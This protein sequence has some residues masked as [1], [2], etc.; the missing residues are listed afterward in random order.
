MNGAIELPGEASPLSVQTLAATLHAAT[1]SSQQQIQTST[2]QLQIW[3]SNENYYN[4]LQDIFM[5]RE[6]PLEVRSPMT[7]TTKELYKRHIIGN[8]VNEPNE[9]LAL[10]NALAIAKIIRL[11]FPEKWPT[12]ITEVLDHL[13]DATKPGAPFIQLPRTLL[14]LL[15]IIKELSTGRLMRSRKSLQSISPEILQLLG[16]IYV[17]KVQNWKAYLGASDAS[18]ENVLDSM[19]QSLLAIKILRRLLITGI[20]HPHREKDVQEFWTITRLHQGEFSTTLNHGSQGLKD[21]FAGL[22]E[23]HLIQISKLHV[24]M[25]KSHPA[26]FA[27]LPGS[28]NLLQAYWQLIQGFSATYGSKVPGTGSKIG[29]NGDADEEG[30]LLPEKLCLKGLLLFRA[31]CKMTFN[32]VH[33]FKYQH[34]Q[35]KEERKQSTELMK[36]EVLTDGLVLNMM[37]TLVTKFFVFRASDLKEWEE[38]PEEWERREE[39]LEN[40]WEFSVRTCSEKLFLDLMINFDH[41]LKEPLLTVFATVSTPQNRDILLKDSIYSAIGLAA[42]VLESNLDFDTF[43]SNTLVPE[44]QV[45]EQGYNILRRRIA[46]LLGQWVPVKITGLNRPLVY[47]IF[48]HLLDNSDPLNDQVVRVTAARQFKNIADPFEFVVSD[49]MPYAPDILGRIMSLIE[50]VEL[51]EIKMALLD[52]IG[53]LVVKLES[54]ITLYSDQIVSLLPALWAQSGEQHLMKQAIL[55]LLTRLLTSMGDESRRYHQL[56]LPLIQNSLEPN[57]EAA[58]YLLEDALDLWHTVLIQ[59]PSPASPELVALSNYLF[60]IYEVGSENLRKALDI[61]ESYFLLAP[62]ALLA[63]TLR[64]RFLNAFAALLGSLKNDA[65]GIVPHVVE[66]LLQQ[67]ENLGGEAALTILT[68]DLVESGFLGKLLEGLHN[69]YQANQGTGPNRKFP[70]I[71]GVVETDYFS[72]LARLA[73][74]SPSNFVAAIQALGPSRGEDVDTTMDWLLKEWFGH[75]DVIGD[76]SRK[77]LMCLAVTK[78]LETGSGWMLSKLQDLMVAWTGTV[79]ELEEGLLFDETAEGRGKDCLVFWDDPNKLKSEDKESPEEERRRHLLIHDP[80]HRIVLRDFIRSHLQST[81]ANCG[82]QEAFQRD[83]LVNVDKDIVSSFGGLE[84]LSG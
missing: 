55:A 80:V 56:I 8:G 22:I 1:T 6:L 4:F 79:V 72:V 3:E 74:A 82:G 53:V 43:L 19:N 24:D 66:I 62:Q 38:E 77:K 81:I 2:R 9:Q 7:P 70:A 29:A 12:A 27:L 48:Q 73:L 18:E 31:C 78:L 16:Q 57:S 67:G 25:I 58:V 20:E 17:E 49:F 64:P 59:T 65:N 44:V 23:R 50:E 35:D 60:Q 83:W 41:L 37:E 32:P 30:P 52:T 28:V 76:P 36:R 84:I 21:S 40:A 14:I 34:P 5:S 45:Q 75:F 54:H 11:E 51:P 47:Q 26:A 33:T 69:S 15:Q 13:R 61:S 63:D 10:Q 46:I 71:H 42:A 68:R 39:G